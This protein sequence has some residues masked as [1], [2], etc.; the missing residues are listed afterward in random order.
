MDVHGYKVVD[1]QCIG[2]GE[3]NIFII[4]K[5]GSPL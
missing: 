3:N 1:V 2:D 4:C 5:S